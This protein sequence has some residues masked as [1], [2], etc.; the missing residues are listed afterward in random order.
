[1]LGEAVRA[2]ELLDECGYHLTVVNLPWLNRVDDA[3]L[4]GLVGDVSRLVLIEDHYTDL[5][6][7]AFIAQALR[8]I[9]SAM[10]TDVFG[11]D[12]VPA[13]GENREV[14]EHHGL[15]AERLADRIWA[16]Q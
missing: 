2:A 14:L 15:S 3:W 16:S 11:V 12:G 1:M 10:R 4:A 7:S 9:G 8:R 5:G 6:Q 13:C